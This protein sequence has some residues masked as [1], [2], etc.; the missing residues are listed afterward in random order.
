MF[1]FNLFLYFIDAMFNLFLFEHLSSF[2][3]HTKS[4][5]NYFHVDFHFEVLCISNRHASQNQILG[6]ITGDF[7]NRG[8][9]PEA[10]QVCIS[11]SILL[12]ISSYNH[13]LIVFLVSEI[14]YLC[15]KFCTRRMEFVSLVRFKENYTWNKAT[16]CVHNILGGQQWVDHYGE[17]MVVNQTLNITCKL[18]YVKVCFSYPWIYAEL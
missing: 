10:S 1:G 13:S 5:K 16:S 11:L 2:I 9:Q 3:S 8:C 14:C 18:T 4:W 12:L 17:V 7:A 6:K 15:V